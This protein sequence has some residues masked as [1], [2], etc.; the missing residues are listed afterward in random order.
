LFNIRICRGTANGFDFVSEAV[1]LAFLLTLRWEE[2]M[3]GSFLRDETGVTAMEYGLLAGLI[4]VVIIGS[5]TAIGVN[6][7]NKFNTVSNNLS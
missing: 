1:L 6:L 2:A 4:A 7:G 5:I 3:I